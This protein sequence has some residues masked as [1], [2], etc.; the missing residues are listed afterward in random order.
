MNPSSP[1]RGIA[2]KITAVL[3]FT[4]LA[5]LVR[6]IG[7][8]VPPAEV[9]SFRA[10]FTLI[11]LLV[12][13]AFSGSLKDAVRTK[14][15]LSHFFRGLTGIFA[16]FSNFTGL[17][18]LPLAE[19]TAIGFAMPLFSVVFAAMFLA[20]RVRLF[21][22]SA[23]S[24]GFIGVVIILWPRFAGHGDLSNEAAIGALACVAGAIF[25]A[26]AVVQIRRLTLTETTPAIVFYF[27]FYSTLMTFLTI[28]FGW[29]WPS[30]AWALAGPPD[31]RRAW[32]APACWAALGQILHDTEL[33]LRRRLDA[34]RRSTIRRSSGRSIAGWLAVPGDPRSDGL[35]RRRRIVVLAGLVVIWREHRLGLERSR[36]QRGHDARMTGAGQTG[37]AFRAGRAIGRQVP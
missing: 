22:F 34:G 24:V 30:Q 16:M 25:S 27:S 28:P 37:P 26:S 6:Y 11:P 8:R 17:A 13:L 31:A 14:Q 5:A 7:T 19:A 20:E 2:L 10:G 9:V 12:W 3:C 21:R 1:S 15:P 29:V 33:P 23:V 36:E 32:S 18:F 4:G 35:P